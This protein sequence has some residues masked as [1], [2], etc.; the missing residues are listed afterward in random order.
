MVS[1]MFGASPIALMIGENTGE[2]RRARAGAEAAAI[3]ADISAAVATA[4]SGPNYA[5]TSAGLA[6]T[7]NGQSFAVDNG[8]GTV[9]VYRNN[10]GSAAPQRTLATT[11]TIN[12]RLGGIGKKLSDFGNTA[13]SSATASALTASVAARSAEPLLV[14][15]AYTLPTT[16]S[17]FDIGPAPVFALPGAS[18][19]GKL[20]LGADR[21]VQ[22]RIAATYNDGS[23]YFD[24]TLG[25]KFRRPFEER[26]RPL[27]LVCDAATTIEAIDCTTIETSR[28]PASAS[29]TWTAESPTTTA[30]SVSYLLTND[31][32]WHVAWVPVQGGM[33]VTAAI[34]G[35]I[36]GSIFGV[37]IRTTKGF[38]Y[39]Y[40]TAG[41]AGSFAVKLAGAAP[42]VT[43]GITWLGRGSHDSYEFH[44]SLLTVRALQ[45]RKYAI[46]LNGTEIFPVRDLIAPGEIIA[47]GFGVFGNGSSAPVIRNPV[48]RVTREVT[49]SC[50]LYIGITGNSISDGAVHG[51][52]PAWMEEALDGAMGLKVLGVTNLAVSGANSA[53]IAAQIGGGAL[54]SSNVCLI[55]APETNDVQTGAAVST[56]TGNIGTMI[57]TLIASGVK[58]LLVTG[59]LWY[60]KTLASGQGQTT[61]NYAE[62]AEHRSALRRLAATKGVAY[63]DLAETSG[64]MLATYLA[65]PLVQDPNVR[66]NLHPTARYYQQIGYWMAR[67]ILRAFRPKMTPCVFDATFPTAGYTW[68]ANSWTTSDGSWSLGENGFLHLNGVFTAGTKTDGTTVFTLPPA[69]R[70]AGNRY[71]TLTADDN[72]TGR[73]VLQCQADGACKIYSM[74]AT[75]TFV[76]INGGFCTA[77]AA[78]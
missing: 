25:R 42:S 13:T 7:T 74:D 69:L 78:K 33:D 24:Y 34:T 5:S 3:A 56:T 1:L 37:F 61:T 51:S 19:S 10:A 66:D 28:W 39:F 23:V 77:L 49:G 67:L 72:V 30:A 54:G 52:W 68:M 27:D 6:A 64:P 36:S 60:P 29:D 73:A 17:D 9:T 48:R 63:F 18:L 16:G 53:G 59:P 21:R 65:N 8:D 15:K 44:K 62:G 76:R 55:V 11:T 20:Y 50:P 41:L 22:D 75:A 40:A 38:E 35:A 4:A 2:A 57:D 31:S 71:L 45:G 32:N 47:V 46:M 12:T 26:E 58:P 70:P 14:D 43:S